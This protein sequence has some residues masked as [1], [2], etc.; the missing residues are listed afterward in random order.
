MFRLPAVWFREAMANRPVFECDLVLPGV[1]E[2][3][4]TVYLPAVPRA[5]E[6]LDLDLPGPAAGRSGAYRVAGVT[7]HVRPRRFAAEAGAL[8][9]ISLA[10]TALGQG[11]PPPDA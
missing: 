6:V 11:E 4:A 5:G 1:A 9:G 7:Y 2:A 8:A 10:L 3:F